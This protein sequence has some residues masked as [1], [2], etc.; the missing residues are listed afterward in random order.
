MRSTNGDATSSIVVKIGL[1][2]ADLGILLYTISTLMGSQAEVLFNNLNLKRFGIDTILIWLV[3]SKVAYEFV[4]NFPYPLLNNLQPFIPWI[5]L[6]TSL[7]AS[8]INLMKNILVLFF[9]LIILSV[10]GFYMILKNVKRKFILEKI[11]EENVEILKEKIE[12]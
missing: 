7:D 11:E 5:E 8:S 1:L 12:F 2:I 4:R 3:F 6:L 9:F 10:L